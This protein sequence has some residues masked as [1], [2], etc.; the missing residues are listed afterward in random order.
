MLTDFEYKL[1][2][3]ASKFLDEY[4]DRLASDTCNDWDWPKGLGFTEEEKTRIVKQYHVW[5]G[6]PEE[7]NPNYINMT[8]FAMAYFISKIL[9]EVIENKTL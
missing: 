9:D 6:D 2:K 1:L 7:F 5:N 3:L 8:N 4:S